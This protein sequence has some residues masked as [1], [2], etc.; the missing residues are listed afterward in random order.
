MRLAF[1]MMM[2]LLLAPGAALA[3]RGRSA[4]ELIKEAE[5]LYD[6][7][8]YEE[9]VELLLQA[10]TLA[11]HPRLLYN[12]ARA[13]DQAGNANAAIEYY[14]KYLGTADEGAPEVRK[15]ARLSVERLQLQQKKEDEANRAAEAERKRLQ[16][17]AEA[18]RRRAEEEAEL[19]RRAEEANQLRR[20]A[21]L[22]S[23]VAAHRRSQVMSFALGGVAVAGAGTGIFFGLQATQARA[24]LKDATTLQGKEAVVSDTRGKALVADIGFGVGL[25]SAVAA[26]MLYPKS[27][28]PTQEGTARL[29][30]APRGL[31]AGLEVS[32]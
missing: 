30:V 21:D 14:L 16:E 24:G 29:T 18:S 11:P 17:E 12:I 27:P 31:G 26:V 28:A 1:V 13:Y 2:A 4:K 20:K 3:Q 32:F 8:K 25:A 22:E 9:S 15:R 5:R 19:A 23:A 6:A 7:R 10:Y